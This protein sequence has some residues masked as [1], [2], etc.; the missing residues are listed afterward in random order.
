M[1][2]QQLDADGKFLPEG[3]EPPPLSDTA[4]SGF[5]SS[6]EDY[7][8][9]LDADS[10]PEWWLRFGDGTAPGGST[11]QTMSIPADGILG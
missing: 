11:T 6:R 9:R 4:G 3:Q 1:A 5:R 7:A 8:G 2:D 10:S